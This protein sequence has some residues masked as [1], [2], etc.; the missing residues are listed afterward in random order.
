MVGCVGGMRVG[1]GWEE[2][3]RG[4]GLQ[5]ECSM[6]CGSMCVM[7][8]GVRMLFGGRGRQVINNENKEMF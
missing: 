3:G 4:E 1:G 5:P 2:E 6:W 8:L 7:A